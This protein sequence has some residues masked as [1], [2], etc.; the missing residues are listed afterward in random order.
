MLALPFRVL[1]LMFL[2]LVPGKTRSS[3]LLVAIQE[4]LCLDPFDS[5]EIFA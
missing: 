1:K 3:L 2:V 4:S 5:P